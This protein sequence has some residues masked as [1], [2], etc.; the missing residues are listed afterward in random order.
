MGIV[1]GKRGGRKLSVGG[2]GGGGR[3]CGGRGRGV[4]GRCN[5][6]IGGN[7]VKFGQ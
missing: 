5:R 3:G 2:E 7:E 1:E 4:N 6:R